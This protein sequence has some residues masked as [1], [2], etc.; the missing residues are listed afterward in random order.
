MNG[1][2]KAGLSVAHLIFAIYSM[3]KMIMWNFYHDT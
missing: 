2:M 1:R 3:S